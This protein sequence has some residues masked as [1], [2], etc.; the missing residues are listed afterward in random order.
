MLLAADTRSR[1]IIP[2][3]NL[4]NRA[5]RRGNLFYDNSL[6]AFNPQLWANASLA[7]LYENLLMAR[8]VNRDFDPLIAKYGNIVHTRKPRGFTAKRKTNADSVTVQDAIADDIPVRL[9]QFWHVS[10]L[11]KDGEESIAFKSIIDEFLRPAMIANARAI[12]LVLCGQVYQFQANNAGRLNNLDKTN[13][14]DYVLDARTTLNVNKCWVNDRNLMLTPISE[15]TFL[16]VEDFT[17]PLINDQAIE[18]AVL[19]DRLGFHIMMS[20]NMPHVTTPAVGNAGQG[21]SVRLGAINNAGGYPAGTTTFTVDGITGA[22]PNGTYITIAGDDTPLHVASTTGGATPTVIVTTTGSKRAV[23]DNAVITV[24]NG[25]AVSGTYN[26]DSVSGLGYAK[27]I[28]LTGMTVAPQI[29]QQ[30]SFGTDAGIYCIIDVN[31]LVGITLDRPLEFSLANAT[32]V[33]FGPS[34]SFNLAFHP[35]CMTLVSR[36]LAQ[37]R[38]GTGALSG[39]ANWEAL[40]IRVVISYN[41]TMQGHLVTLDILMGVKVLDTNLACVLYG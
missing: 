9:N 33:N 25:G 26:I 31:G 36:P 5:I 34:G 15:G 40:S 24:Y 2:A 3:R 19:G 14:R 20:Q 35:N 23:A 4:S 16:N 22:I 32:V 39:V 28:T 38:A 27:E 18:N 11:I 17:T 1:R 13:T 12:D 41:G 6:E 21:G 7:L 30:V 10:Y 8:M 37:P 29:G